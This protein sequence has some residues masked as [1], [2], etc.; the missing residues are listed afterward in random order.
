MEKTENLIKVIKIMN[1]TSVNKIKNLTVSS[2]L[3][4]ISIGIPIVFPKII[5][6]PPFTATL[7][8]HVPIMIAACISASTVAFVS[9]GSIIGFYF[10]FPA[11][12]IVPARVFT[13][14]IFAMVGHYMLKKKINIYIVVVITALLHATF[15]MLLVFIPVFYPTHLGIGVAMSVLGIGTFIHHIVDV[16]ITAPILT[17]LKKNKIITTCFDTIKIRSSKKVITEMGCKIEN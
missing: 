3:L 9:V 11:L 14:V 7:A 17:V 15:E 1:N 2:M 16:V 5:V 6:I 12:P 13:H 10:A 4:A 8:A